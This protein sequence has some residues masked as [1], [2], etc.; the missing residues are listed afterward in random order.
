MSLRIINIVCIAVFQVLIFLNFNA[1][2]AQIPQFKSIEVTTKIS[3]IR[4][5]RIEQDSAGYVWLGTNKGLLKFNGK[6]YRE[7]NLE[8]NLRNSSVTSLLITSAEVIVGFDNGHIARINP[9][10]LMSIASNKVSDVAITSLVQSNDKAIWAGTEGHGLFKIQNSE[11]TSYTTTNGLAD[12][13]VHDL[14]IIQNK[15]AVATDLGLSL[16]DLDNP[17]FDCNNFGTAQGLTDNLILALKAQNNENL[18]MGMQNG[19]ICSINLQTGSVVDFAM[20]KNLDLSPVKKVLIIHD[21]ILAITESSGAYVIDGADNIHVQKFLLQPE[22]QTHRMPLDCLVDQEGNLILVFGDN[23]LVIANF[24][25]QFIREHDEE[26]FSDAQCLITDRHGNLWFANN[27]GIFK[28]QAEFSTDQYIEKFYSTPAGMSKIIALC[29]GLN[30]EIWFGSLGGGLGVIDTKKKSIKYYNEKNGLVN[31]NVLSIARQ[32]SVIWMAT[33]GG[34]ASM[35][36]INGKPSFETFDARSPL[37]S[38]YI[39]SV[40]VDSR[41][42]VWFGT[43]GNGLVSYRNQQFNTFSNQYHDA[44]KH[45]IAVTEDLDNNIWFASTDKG[46]QWTDGEILRAVKLNTSR[47]K[48]EVFAIQGDDLGNVIALTSLGIAVLNDN[49]PHATFLRTGIDID[50]NY[51][52]VISKDNQGRMWLGTEEAMIRYSDFNLARNNKPSTQ[53]ESIKVMLLIADTTQHEYTHD[54]NH[55]T[56]HFASIW[57]QQPD[58]ITFQYKLDGLDPEWITTHDYSAVFPK[59]APGTYTFMVRS[60]H[61][62]DWANAII[63]SYTFNIKIPYWNETWFYLLVFLVLSVIVYLIL[64][65]RLSRIRKQELLVRE[66]LQSQFDILRN[67]INPHFLFNSFNTLISVISIDPEDAISYVEK[68]SDYFRLVLEQR[69][70]DV[71]SV[72]EELV[73][74]KNYLYL[75]QRRFGDNL[76]VNIS[77]DEE[78]L[79]SSIPPMSL[80]LLVENAIKHNV[81]S[82]SHP[83]TI[84]LKGIGNTITIANTIREKI[85]REPST[86]IG[87]SNIGRRYKILFEKEIEILHDKNEFV[88]TLPVI[89]QPIYPTPLE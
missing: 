16:C 50:A 5:L 67:Q 30:D 75:Q 89:N 36:T 44:G 6:E 85:T 42:T 65:I 19:T 52:N 2:D 26:L 32:D 82:K 12:D 55:F 46:L 1:A 18:L 22:N 4:V 87:L 63:K 33:L 43:D 49:T 71:I 61:N 88:V 78:V 69:D 7:A 60:S 48:V 13:F 83:L 39:Y 11:I 51:L 47:E 15:L 77:F 35:K 10:T 25:I 56:F 24:T 70:K 80:Q 81:V 38:N 23:Q 31:N 72:S 17:I 29:E 40:F 79:N 54:N 57:L 86:G 3:E 34:A 66:R 21:D 62:E 76:K 8:F 73:M 45:I 59:L 68:L 64:K 27:H 28:H 84:E 74:V 14:A 58:A 9:Q 37:G 53:I 41:N 20:L